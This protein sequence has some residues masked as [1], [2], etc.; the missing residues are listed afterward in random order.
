MTLK[1]YRSRLAATTGDELRYAFL[2]LLAQEGRQHFMQQI[3]ETDNG[4][5]PDHKQLGAC[6]A[7]TE[8]G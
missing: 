1:H 3:A 6:Q 8:I 7:T 4:N 2:K 5:P